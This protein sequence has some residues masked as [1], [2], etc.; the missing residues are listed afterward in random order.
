MTLTNIQN[1]TGNTYRFVKRCSMRY[2]MSVENNTELNVNNDLRLWDREYET[3][4][5]FEAEVYRLWASIPVKVC[6]GWITSMPRRMRKCIK[7]KGGKT[8]Y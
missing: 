3:Y 8:D 4:A 7:L 1:I 6:R 5:D 2:D